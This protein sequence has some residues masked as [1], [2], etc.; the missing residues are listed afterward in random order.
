MNVILA[1][2]WQRLTKEAALTL[3]GSRETILAIS[4]R[5]NRKTQT[6]RLHWQASTLTYQLEDIC[7]NVGRTLCDLAALETHSAIHMTRTTRPAAESQLL[8]AATTAR[9]I[10]HE[11]VLLEESIR[12]LE[13]EALHE[14]FIKIQ[15]DLTSRSANLLRLVVPP[16]SPLIGLSL[17][18]LNLP[19]TT[20]AAAFLRGPTLLSCVAEIPVKTGDIII[21]V[22]PQAELSNL[23][24]QV[25]N[26]HE[27]EFDKATRNTM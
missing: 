3:T 11:L 14:E 22:G 9:S 26:R 17:A 27:T 23:M 4:E 6:L 25:T 15:R 19:E 18:R 8:E 1:D 7:R 20:R 5:V 12:E 24:G 13:I 16:D 21:L 10:K 2:L